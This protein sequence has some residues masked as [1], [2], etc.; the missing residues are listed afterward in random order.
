MWNVFTAA[1][2]EKHKNGGPQLLSA[3]RSIRFCD[4]FTNF[5]EDLKI[6]SILIRILKMP[7]RGSIE[8]TS[9]PLTFIFV[10]Y[11]ILVN[12]TLLLN[13]GWL[14]YSL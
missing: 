10:I 1:S 8:Y 13:L 9:R 11:F 5:A 6:L 2:R 12:S 4:E 14:P 7:L 3:M